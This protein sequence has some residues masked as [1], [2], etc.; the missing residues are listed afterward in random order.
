MERSAGMELRSDAFSRAVKLGQGQAWRT[1]VTSDV[2][3]VMGEAEQGNKR[4]EAGDLGELG[5]E[6]S[7]VE[8]FS[9]IY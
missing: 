8:T 2:A 3:G 5:Q 6:H 9:K 1:D 7:L 4:S